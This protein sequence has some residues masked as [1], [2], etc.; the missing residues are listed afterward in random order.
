MGLYI[1][2]PLAGLFANLWARSVIDRTKMIVLDL[3]RAALL[4]LLPF[5]DSVWLIFA[6]SFVLQAASTA[7]SA[8][9][10]P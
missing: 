10:C 6:V 5:A 3:S 8:I 2:R 7:F 9:F 4:C 1:I